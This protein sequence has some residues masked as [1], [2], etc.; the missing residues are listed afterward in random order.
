MQ[1]FFFI[2][3]DIFADKTFK[4]IVEV[5]DEI[6]EEGDSAF[7]KVKGT[8]VGMSADFGHFYRFK[9]G[10]IIE[11]WIMDDSQKMAHAMRAM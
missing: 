11:Q 2:S 7:A 9:D 5:L 6:I 10:K 8:A 4:G 1:K 3:S